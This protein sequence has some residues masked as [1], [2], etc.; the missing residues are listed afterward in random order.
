MEPAEYFE[1]EAAR[2]DERGGAPAW[3]LVRSWERHAV[4]ALL[5]PVR[6]RSV[7]ELGCGT[8][9]YASLLERAG[10]RV[11]AVDASPSMVERARA[12]GL[13]AR[14]GDVSSLALPERFGLVLAAG[15]VEFLEQPEPCFRAAAAAAEPGARLV[16]LVPRGGLPGLVYARWHE[17]HGCRTRVPGR[18][19]LERAGSRH[20][21]AV[22]Q[23]RGAGPLAVAVRFARAGF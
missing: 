14:V 12:K 23:W 7:L 22:E 20:G 13:D 5:G 17:R 21:W 18:A 19:E 3:R 9:H 8:G 6:G 11:V 15:L 4:R 10:A 2:Y 1:R 16:L